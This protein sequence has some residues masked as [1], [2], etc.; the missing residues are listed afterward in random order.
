MTEDLNFASPV[1]ATGD[2]LATFMGARLAASLGVL[3]CAKFGLADP[4]SATV[5]GDGVATA[6]SYKLTQQK[7]TI[8]VAAGGTATPTAAPSASAGT[9]LPWFGAP[10]RRHRHHQNGTGM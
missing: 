8:P 7:A 3:D 9:G 4:V 1:P 10:P 6:I 2:N 5:D